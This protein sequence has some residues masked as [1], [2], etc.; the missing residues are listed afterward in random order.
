MKCLTYRPV[1]S[2]ALATTSPEWL[3]IRYNV[4]LNVKLLDLFH[5]FG[6]IL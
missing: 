5:F 6:G 1:N 2:D 3:E 4:N